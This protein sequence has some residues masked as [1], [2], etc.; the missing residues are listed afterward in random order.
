VRKQ[1]AAVLLLFAGFVLALLAGLCLARLL[2][3]SLND[4]IRYTGTTLEILALFAVTAALRQTILRRLFSRR[5]R[6]RCTSR[7]ET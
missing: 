3:A 4:F 1:G 7:A 6:P 5:H 2:A